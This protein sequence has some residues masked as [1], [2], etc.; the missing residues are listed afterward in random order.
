M[1]IFR[2]PSRRRTSE[3]PEVSADDADDADDAVDADDGDAADIST[4]GERAA[5]DRLAALGAPADA[6]RGHGPYDRGEVADSGG[7]LDLG[8]LWVAGLPG[9]ELR[10]ELEEATGSVVAVTMAVGDSAVQL[11]AFA[12]PR[13]EGLWDEIRDEIAASITRQGGTA[14]VVQGPLGRELHA[15]MPSPGPNGRTVFGP[16]RF[17]GVDGPRWFLRA[18]LSGRAASDPDAAGPLLDIVR[19]TVVVRGTEAMAP[20]DLLPLRMPEDAIEHAADEHAEDEHAQPARSAADLDP[21]AR[22]P[23]I[24]EIR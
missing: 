12:A 13:S 22:G 15:R 11:Q 2:R 9:M 5:M 10:L 1:S 23:E 20:R 17:L 14:D 4:E 24:T 8:S 19:A 21:F 3:D 7:R 16:A 6:L 18:V